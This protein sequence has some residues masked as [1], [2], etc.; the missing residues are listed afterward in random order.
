[1]DSQC[2]MD[3][4]YPHGMLIT[5]SICE[6]SL[7]ISHLP[8]YCP[9]TVNHRTTTVP[10]TTSMECLWPQRQHFMVTSQQM[11]ILICNSLEQIVPCL[12]QSCQTIQWA[13]SCLWIKWPGCKSWENSLHLIPWRNDHAKRDVAVTVMSL[14]GDQNHPERQYDQCEPIKLLNAGKIHQG[15]LPLLVLG[16]AWVWAELVL[17]G[18]FYTFGNL[19][20]WPDDGGLLI[21]VG[22]GSGRLGR[23][24]GGS[25]EAD[26]LLD[27]IQFVQSR[28][29][30]ILRWYRVIFSI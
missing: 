24:F 15:G 6:R 19:I 21:N 30:N 18:P 7:F 12:S 2:Y 20:H 9:S 29:S 23:D 5:Q 4:Q 13:T 1:M 17:F 8:Y 16:S 28:P 26:R 10:H 27:I 22:S 11:W 3:P 25:Q 14:P